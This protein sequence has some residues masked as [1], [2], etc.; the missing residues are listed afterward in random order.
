MLGDVRS[1]IEMVERAEKVYDNIEYTQ[2]IS[3]QTIASLYYKLVLL[4]YQVFD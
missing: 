3:N 4:V 2:T 1:V